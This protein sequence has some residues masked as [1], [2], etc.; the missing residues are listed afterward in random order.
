MYF[1]QIAVIAPS[2]VHH[3]VYHAPV[4]K[5]A[6]VAVVDVHIGRDLPAAECRHVGLFFGHVA[7]HGIKQPH[8]LAEEIQR[9]VQK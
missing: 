1:I 8:T 5:S 9:I 7:V 2:V 3:L 4:G 6:Q